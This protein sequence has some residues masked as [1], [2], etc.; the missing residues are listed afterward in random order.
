MSQYV[1]GLD[2]GG[3]SSK[4]VLFDMV[5]REIAS[6]KR[7]TRLLTPQAGFTER[8]MEELWQVNCQ[9]IREVL[10]KSGVDP[11]AVAGVSFS[12]HGK[13]LYLWGK[14][15]RPVR[16]GIVST[17]SRAH[18]FVEEWNANGVA[19]RAFQK[20]YQSVLASQPVAL[21]KWLQAHEPDA[22]ERTRWIF[23][24]KDYIRYRMT[25]E[26]FAEITDLSGSSL[27]N[28]ETAS[29]DGQLLELFG[30]GEVADKLPPIARSAEFCGRVT[31]ECARLTGLAEGTPA[32]AGLFDI[33]A[34]A[35]GM[36]V[37]DESVLAVIAGTWSINEYIARR[38]VLDRSVKMNSLYCLPGW[39]LA[40][41]CSP[42]SA[43]NLEWYINNLLSGIPH[44]PGTSLYDVANELVAGAQADAGPLVFLPYLFGG[45]DD[46]RARA[47]FVGLD[48][49]HTHADLL[50]AV[51]ECVAFGHKKHIERL[52]KSR[53]GP[54]RAIRL[55]GGVVNCPMWVQIFADILEMPVETIEVKELGALGAAM[56]AAVAAGR[57][58][59]LGE[60]A[61]KMVRVARVYQPDA[62]RRQ[63]YRKKYRAFCA[64]DDAL[65]GVWEVLDA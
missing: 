26:A 48:A 6:A 63:E 32:A 50:R 19:G 54:P 57:Y 60:A 49:R 17:D 11:N 25:G 34:C 1:L 27:L 2:N 40:E 20:T 51:Y 62:Q 12:G 8:D 46:A 44:A 23:G 22:L 35:I 16:A 42:T 14:D 64:V 33:D 59:G 39:Y 9:V 61:E 65:K 28:L 53:Q 38:P 18:A 52:L 58:R 3:T 24:V 55:A 43:S 5:G 4:A 21:L 45:S 37:V 29:Y 31:A 30:L 36:N 10:E 13:G 7:N 41:E 56:T 15:E 47:A